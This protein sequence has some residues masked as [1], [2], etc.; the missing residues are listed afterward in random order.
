MERWVQ[1]TKIFSS[2]ANFFY[3][4]EKPQTTSVPVTTCQRQTVG[5]NFPFQKLFI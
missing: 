3:D 1:G 5:V 4:P 2:V